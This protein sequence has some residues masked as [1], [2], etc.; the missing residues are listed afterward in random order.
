MKA[1][2]CRCCGYAR[3]VDSLGNVRESVTAGH[4]ERCPAFLVSLLDVCSVLHQQLHTLQVPREDSLMDRCHTCRAVNGNGWQIASVQVNCRDIE[5]TLNEQFILR[6]YSITA[7]ATETSH[8]TNT[9]GITDDQVFG[10]VKPSLNLTR[11]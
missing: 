4:V 1:S 10:T 11:A 7:R 9:G 3:S 6:H 8:C 5:G 2:D